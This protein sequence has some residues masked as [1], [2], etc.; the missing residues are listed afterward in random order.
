MTYLKAANQNTSSA[1]TAD[2]RPP[3]KNKFRTAA[4]LSAILLAGNV[5][6]QASKTTG[7]A[8]RPPYVLGP[9]GI[10]KRFLL[11]IG[12]NNNY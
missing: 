2:M 1:T 4:L 11:L 3:S 8:F 5:N 12:I 6:S 7:S 9:A 10:G